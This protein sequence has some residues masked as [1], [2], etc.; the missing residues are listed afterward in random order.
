MDWEVVYW[1]VEDVDE[2]IFDVES[3]EVVLEVVLDTHELLPS[4]PR[5]K[6]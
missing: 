2:A 5:F 4:L 1:D 6:E 3:C